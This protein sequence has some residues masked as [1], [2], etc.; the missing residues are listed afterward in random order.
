[1]DLQYE[2]DRLRAYVQHRRNVEA[3]LVGESG[4]HHQH[5]HQQQQHS[6][7]T[8]SL[9]SLPSLPSVHGSLGGLSPPKTIAEGGKGMLPSQSNQ[10][11]LPLSK[12]EIKTPRR[13][14][15]SFKNQKPSKASLGILFFLHFSQ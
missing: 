14:A 7:S 1:M 10:F 5:Q 13:L 2:R 4:L 3:T 8:T 15:I 11:R 12:Q 6:H 9:P